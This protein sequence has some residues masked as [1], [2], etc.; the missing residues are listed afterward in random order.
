MPFSFPPD[1]EEGSSVQLLC[2]MTSGDRPVYF[3]WLKDGQPLPASL[4]VIL[5]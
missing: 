5:W 2:G 4:Q 1:L 3:S